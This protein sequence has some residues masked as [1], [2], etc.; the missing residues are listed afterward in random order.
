MEDPRTDTRLVLAVR[1][2]DRDAFGVLVERHLARVRA[3]ARRI[4]GSREEGEDVAQEA[5]LRAYLGIGDLRDPR[6]FGS[7]LCGI[8]VNL[9]K[10]RLRQRRDRLVAEPRDRATD[11]AAEAREALNAVQEALVVLPPHERRTV[12]MYYLEG[13]SC[14]EIA[15][16][17]GEPAGTVRVRLHRAR[18]RLRARLAPFAPQVQRRRKEIAGMVEV[19]VEDVVV[20]VLSERGDDETPRLA[21]ERLRI[22]LLRERGGERALPIWVGPPE[23]DAIAYQLGGEAAPRPLTADLMARLV[24]VAGAT[25]E[26][27]VV[28]SL[29]EKT[30][31]GTIVVSAGGTS[32][33]LDA[34]PSD[35]LN[36][37]LR[38]GAPIFVEDAVMDSSAGELPAV[39]DRDVDERLSYE[40]EEPTEWQSLSTE[41][42]RTLWEAPR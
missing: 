9:S 2:G 17:L 29:R 31:Y 16:L 3:L 40:T 36:L 8:A 41:L 39:L 18:Q 15:G 7:W 32:H 35:A 38:V 22:V 4:L 21:N 27:V 23:G 1:S 13:L 34:R 28:N 14:E 30:F 33:E 20:R 6:R 42:V 10:M 24:A 25:I 26:R 5:L 12:L 37:A 19:Q 11:A